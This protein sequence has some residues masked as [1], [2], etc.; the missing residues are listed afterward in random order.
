[1]IDADYHLGLAAIIAFMPQLQQTYLI[2]HTFLLR[3]YVFL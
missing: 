3:K 2:L 1:V